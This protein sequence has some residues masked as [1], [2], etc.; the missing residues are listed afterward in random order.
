[1]SSATP[2]ASV[3]A[4]L[5]S[6]QKTNH[7][8]ALES[9]DLWKLYLAIKCGVGQRA[10]MALAREANAEFISNLTPHVVAG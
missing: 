9:S 10:L 5:C 4:R 2:Q 3:V 7:Q 6:R 8:K 1:M